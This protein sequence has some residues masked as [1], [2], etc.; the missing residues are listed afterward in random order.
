[1]TTARR[2]LSAG[3]ALAAKGNLQ[4]DFSALTES[5]SAALALLFD[6]LRVARRGGFS[7]EV[8]GLADGLRSLA[9][10]YGVAD[11]LPLQD[12]A[13]PGR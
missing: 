13:K 6:W 1:M 9:D 10:L 7:L 3:R 11:L 2:Q 8:C 12:A 4:V 5:D